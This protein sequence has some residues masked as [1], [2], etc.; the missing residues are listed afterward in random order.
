MGHLKARS[1]TYREERG[2]VERR[3][4]HPSPSV[5]KQEEVEEKEEEKGPRYKKQHSEGFRIGSHEGHRSV[6][7]V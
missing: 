4:W 2:V 1:K 6:S 7:K 5:K 3:P